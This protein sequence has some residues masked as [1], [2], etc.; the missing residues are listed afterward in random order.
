MSIKQVKPRFHLYISKSDPSRININRN[1]YVLQSVKT[2]WEVIKSKEEGH[3]YFQRL[4]RAMIHLAT[5]P[6]PRQVGMQRTVI[7]PISITFRIDEGSGD[8][9]V[10]HTIV[11][12]A[13][14]YTTKQTP[15]LYRVKAGLDKW[16]IERDTDVAM[17][18]TH[19]W[20][21]NEHS[22]AVAG[23]F[24]TKEEAGDKL[25]EHILG[26]YT[27][28]PNQS[29]AAGNHYS[30]YWLNNDFKNTQHVNSILNHLIKA[31]A[32]KR[33]VRWLVHGEAT[34]V[35]AEA[36]ELLAKKDELKAEA[37]TQ[38]VFFSNPRG[39][40][41]RRAHLESICTS[42]NIEFAGLQLNEHDIVHNRDA[43]INKLTSA[44]TIQ[45]AVVGL[46]FGAGSAFGSD[47]I[48]K[49]IDAATAAGSSMMNSAGYGAAAALITTCVIGAY[50]RSLWGIGNTTFGK[51]NQQWAGN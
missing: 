7:G 25:P 50:G 6:G 37:Q 46:T 21:D 36:L 12:D 40:K 8:I 39:S 20:G 43:L 22:A 49:A 1:L 3:Y 31:H 19:H 18:F 38:R 35:F 32:S 45:T 41:S 29:K 16:N 30:L 51:G 5:N 47:N 2:Q 48:M 4:N 28:S 26:A 23:K 33:R 27:L 34:T 44:G 11:D 42:A 10:H 14:E 13:P 15:G 9:E 17:D 24:K